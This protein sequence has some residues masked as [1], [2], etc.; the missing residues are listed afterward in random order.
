MN[1]ILPPAT[2]RCHR[3]RPSRIPVAL[4]GLLILALLSALAGCG[5][6]YAV[7]YRVRPGETLA[8]VAA[9]YGMSEEG[10]REFNHL[11]PGDRLRPG[12]LVFVPGARRPIAPPGPSS[13]RAEPV[14]PAPAPPPVANAAPS[15]G[16][17]AADSPAPRA[18]RVPPP[19]RAPAGSQVSPRP[20]AAPTAPLRWP[21]EGPVLRGFG[22][23]PAGESRGVDI[24]VPSGS[25]VRAAAR[26]TVT[27]A[28]V[29]AR[30]YGPLVIV[31][32]RGDLFTVY[33]N[34]AEPNVT[35]GETVE[36]GQ[37]IATSGG[38]EGP[39]P[40]HLHFEVRRNETPVDPLL[41]LPPR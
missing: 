39:I 1:R 8:T 17:A 4:R 40:P 12:D 15:S 14:R 35:K 23:G 13:G 31:R 38:A 7:H 3:T 21:I 25:E 24:G 6:P 27:Y 10:L 20:T 33:A 9:R 5:T 36:P 18:A 22:S 28:G 26:G 37:V 29:P 16:G 32:H 11:E 30:A 34:L 19:A 2:F 41:F